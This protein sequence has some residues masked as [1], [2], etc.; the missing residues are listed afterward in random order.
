MTNTP[1]L[2]QFIDTCLFMD[3]WVV[4]AFVLLWKM[5][6]TFDYKYLSRHIS[7]LLAVYLA[8]ELLDLVAPV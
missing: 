4:Y 5:V 1:Y 8:V 6:Q 7:F 2:P 3:I